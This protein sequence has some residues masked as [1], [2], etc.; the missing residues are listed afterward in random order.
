MRLT[1]SMTCGHQ[2]NTCLQH[3]DNTDSRSAGFV[4]DVTKR[5]KNHNGCQINA[6]F[7]TTQRYSDCETV[8]RLY[9]ECVSNLSLLDTN[10][11]V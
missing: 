7:Y 11:A 10:I 4:T 9:N 2:S 5:H 8:R 3:D 1:H 6:A